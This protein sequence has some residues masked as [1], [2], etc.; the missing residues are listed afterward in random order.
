MKV[1]LSFLLFL[2]LS[3]FAQNEVKCGDALSTSKGWLVDSSSVSPR[4]TLESSAGLKTGDTG[5]LALLTEDANFKMAYVI[6]KVRI[7][8]VNGSELTF[9]IIEKMGVVTING[10]ERSNFTAGARVQFTQYEYDKP[11]LIETFW[12]SGS[13]NESGY[14]L[15][16]HKMGEWKLFHEN[17]A[18]KTSYRTDKKGAIEGYYTEYHANGQKAAQG[19]YRAGQKTGLWTEYFDNGEINAQG[20]YYNGSKSGKWIEHDQTGKKVKRKYPH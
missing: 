19:E 4:M 6:G 7:A 5:E 12:P 1:L 17:G 13:I 3:L 16:G 11:E 8:A 20:Y 10:I 15:C 14:M 9:E 18:P 2:P